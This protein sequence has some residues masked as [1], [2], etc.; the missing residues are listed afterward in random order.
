MAR[1]WVLI[2]IR[3]YQIQFPQFFKSPCYT[4]LD[5]LLPYGIVIFR[6]K[7]TYFDGLN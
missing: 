3:I 7:D 5:P 4:L 6:G 2:Y 1:I